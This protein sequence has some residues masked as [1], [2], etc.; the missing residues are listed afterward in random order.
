MITGRIP[1][2]LRECV[3]GDNNHLH[4]VAHFLLNF[5]VTS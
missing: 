1:V 2:V 3:A 4:Y 5:G